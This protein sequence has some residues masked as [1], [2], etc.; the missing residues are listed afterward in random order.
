MRSTSALFLVIVVFVACG[1]ISKRQE[2]KNY[3]V[4]K[5]ISVIESVEDYEVVYT[6][7]GHT[8]IYYNDSLGD[9]IVYYAKFDNNAGKYGYD[10]V[11]EKVVRAEMDSS[12][13]TLKSISSVYGGAFCN[14]NDNTEY[15]IFYFDQQMK[16]HSIDLSMTL[17]EEYS[18]GTSKE[19][20]VKHIL[21]LLNVAYILSYS[22]NEKNVSGWNNM[23]IALEPVQSLLTYDILKNDTIY[24]S[25]VKNHI[26]KLK[27][28]TDGLTRF[29]NLLR[30][31]YESQNT[32]INAG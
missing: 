18:K 31:K 9:F 15:S 2:T 10:R 23:T 5:Y 14:K 29:N 7:D 17:G 20:E 30:E 25:K 32:Y 13:K 6:E 11:K 27:K 19:Q 22:I 21:S 4:H 8:L 1:S 16:G 12:L 24:D 26:S 28:T 3:S